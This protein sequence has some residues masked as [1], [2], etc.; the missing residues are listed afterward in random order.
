MRIKEI[1]HT[2]VHYGHR[3]MHVL[4]KREGYKVNV[5]RIHRLYREQALSLWHKRPK[6]DKAAQ[7]R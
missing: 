6:R 7:V 2:R 4:L 1:A 3:H 5:E